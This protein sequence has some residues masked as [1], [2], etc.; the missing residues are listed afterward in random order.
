MSRYLAPDAPVNRFAFGLPAA[1]GSDGDAAA[2]AGT[3]V[4]EGASGGGR[5]GCGTGDDD[6]AVADAADFVCGA[7]P[8]VV[9]LPVGRATFAC[10][11]NG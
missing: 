10:S 5:G 7:T 9:V 2:A 6:A 3:T 4:V 1:G 8:S 11:S